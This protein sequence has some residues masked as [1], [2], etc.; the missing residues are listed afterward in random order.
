MRVG[1]PALA[2]ATMLF[3]TD[4]GAQ[5]AVRS[6]VA[7]FS[8]E[9]ARAAT[10][11]AAKSQALASWTA[12]AQRVGAGFA[13]WRLADKKVLGCTKAQAPAT[14][15]ECIAY[16]AP[17]TITQNPAKPKRLT[18]TGRNVPYEV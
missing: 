9:V 4:N 5:A 3:V 18:P 1:T 10:E 12:K 8:G 14:G 7:P 6:C 13:N 16:A 2:V 15:F 17:C 11:T